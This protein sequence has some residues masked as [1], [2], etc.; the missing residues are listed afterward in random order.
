MKYLSSLVIILFSILCIGCYSVDT[1]SFVHENYSR[2]GNP[3]DDHRNYNIIPAYHDEKGFLTDIRT[4]NS[5]YAYESSLFWLKDKIFIFKIDVS[6]YSEK[7]IDNIKI[8]NCEIIFNNF[9][10][11][12]NENELINGTTRTSTNSNKPYLRNYIIVE[13]EIDVKT[14]DNYLDKIKNGSIQNSVILN[15]DIDY[16]E[17]G[18]TKN[19]GNSTKYFIDIGRTTYTPK[20]LWGGLP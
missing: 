20:N 4:N 3:Y 2:S 5:A 9:S 15:I 13:K 6:I 11:I 19:W 10:V 1:V 7:G 14:I 18:E 16:E 12:F 17:N 8:N